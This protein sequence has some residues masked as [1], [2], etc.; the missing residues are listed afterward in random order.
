M[1]PHGEHP[2]QLTAPLY[3]LY[4][5]NMMMAVIAMATTVFINNTYHALKLVVENR[6]PINYLCFIQAMLGAVT[7]I[8]LIVL[9]FQFDFR[10]DI[11]MYTAASLN[12]LSTTCIETILLIKVYYCSESSYPILSYGVVL[13]LARF[14]MGLAN[15]LFAKVT[16]TPLLTCTNIVNSTIALML[17]AV[18]ISLNAYLSACFLYSVYNRW[19]FIRAKVYVTLLQDGTTFSVATT[20]TSVV[21]MVFVLLRVL[22]DNSSVLFNVSWV[23]SSKLTLEQLLRTRSLKKSG[24]PRV[25]AINLEKLS[26]AVGPLKKPKMSQK[27]LVPLDS[28]VD[29]MNAMENFEDIELSLIVDDLENHDYVP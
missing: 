16:V 12:L 20:L 11:K 25:H 29:G 27:N 1:S 28:K 15:I 4:Q 5:N 23:V 18:E 8:A 9:F 22:G 14:S 7:N 17:V 19:K 3:L 13:G 10:C 21:M 26:G 6:K 24:L 2:V